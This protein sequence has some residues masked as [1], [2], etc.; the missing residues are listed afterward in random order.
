MVDQLA[1]SR[2]EQ[3]A[4]AAQEKL[5]RI[6]EI[7]TLWSK[8][9]AIEDTNGARYLQEERKI[10]G[11]IS[12]NIRFL[13]KGTQFTYNNKKMTIHEGALV[14]AAQNN[15]GQT[16]AIQITFL[17]SEGRRARDAEGN[18][19]N[20]V[21]YGALTG[22]SVILQRGRP[23]EPIFL[24][25][26]VETALSV[27]ETGVK[28]SIVA[29]LGLANLDKYKIQNKDIYLLA[30]WDGKPDSAS[31]HRL[32]KAAA[33]YTALQNKVSIIMPVKVNEMM[34]QKVDFNDVLKDQGISQVK[35][36]LTYPE[37]N[38][39]VEKRAG[40]QFNGQEPSKVSKAQF[41]GTVGE[42]RY[43]FK[44]TD[45]FM[46]AYDLADKNL[47]FCNKNP[48]LK[49]DRI[50]LE[51]QHEKL[52]SIVASNPALRASVEAKDP[53][54]AKRIND[55]LDRR[56]FEQALQKSRGLNL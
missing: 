12:E 3:E 38:I 33:H 15:E 48:H 21:T 25:E 54:L 35:A 39:A 24:A 29:T 45:E 42:A 53:D 20:K 41:E 55:Q 16:Q 26:G 17:D 46:K 34:G 10:E 1:A 32:E 50:P 30:D 2:A 36:L 7:Q 49:L 18:K 23:N 27:K 9:V 14:V 22:S 43:S 5:A 11:A 40:I 37:G 51:T 47:R 8:A 44:D 13:P 56:E 28:G 6:Q 4:I 31:A 52:L 19:R